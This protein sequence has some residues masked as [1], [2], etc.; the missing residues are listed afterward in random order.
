MVVYEPTYKEERFFGSAIEN[1]LE[2]FKEASDLVIANRRH[3]GLTD[4]T[5]KAYA[6]DSFK[7]D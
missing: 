4:I 1:D 7:C 5:E 6:C 2:K 3:A